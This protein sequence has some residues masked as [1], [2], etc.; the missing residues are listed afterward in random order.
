MCK[1]SLVR[2]YLATP[3]S[4]YLRLVCEFQM[5]QCT[6][7]CKSLGPP[8]QL[9]CFSKGILSIYIYVLVSSVGYKLKLWG[10]CRQ[11][12]IN[13]NKMGSLLGRETV[14]VSALLKKSSTIDFRL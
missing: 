1:L 4:I 11:K 5:L 3:A 12:K 10:K 14:V 2:F 8:H 9:W 13:G 6:V 7:L